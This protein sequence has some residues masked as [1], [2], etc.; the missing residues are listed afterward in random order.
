MFPD[1]LVYLCAYTGPDSDGWAVILSVDTSTWAITI[2]GTALEFDIE[3]GSTPA[4][5]QVTSANYLCAYTGPDDDGW[6]TVLTVNT[7]A[8]TIVKQTS[9]EFDMSRGLTPALCKIDDST[10]LCAY[11]GQGRKGDVCI[12]AVQIGSGT[13]TKTAS[14][15]YS[16]T[17]GE[18][19][20]LCKINDENYLCAYRCMGNKAAAVVLEVDIDSPSISNSESFQFDMHNID[21]WP[22]LCGISLNQYLCA[23]CGF[24]DDGWAFVLRVGPEVRP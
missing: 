18:K 12:L 5:S 17:Q 7:A 2:N 14:F 16:R 9:L 21:V 10:Y 15:C 23:Y 6:A 13:I 24:S 3:Q 20:D 22:A 1:R 4:L 19:P 11:E 8:G